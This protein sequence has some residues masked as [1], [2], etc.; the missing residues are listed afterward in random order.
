MGSGTQIIPKDS[1]H[2]EV[3][4]AGFA[5][6]V[7]ATALRQRGWSVTLHERGPE[8]RALGAGI[9]LWKNSLQV[10]K[11][12]GALDD[13]MSQSMTPPF[14]ETRMNNEVVSKEDFGGLPWRTMTRSALHEA[15]VGA[16]MKSGVEIKVNSYV[17][18]A[19][20]EG[21]LTLESGEIRRADLVV[22]ADGV[23]SKVRDSIGFKQD[24][25]ESRDGI[26]RLIVP[27]NREL[28]GPGDWDNVI[29]FWN[30][31]PRVL[32]V[33]YIPCTKDH[34]YLALMSPKDD[35]EGSAVPINFGVWAENFPHLRPVLEPAAK[36]H[37]RY[38]GYITNVLDNWTKG[39]VALIG[40]SAHAMCPALA[41]GAGT[42]MQNAYTLAVAATASTGSMSDSLVAWE[43]SE[44]GIT[45]R[46]QERSAYFAATRSMAN[47]NQFTPT[48]LETAFYDPTEIGEHLV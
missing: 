36:I 6:L 9:L 5:G 18:S 41:Q 35:K 39:S 17:T 40:D 14:Y 12:I 28:L 38:D 45:D 15:L 42:A 10:L 11:A 7:A 37:G 30:L 29:D 47:G 22:G 20:P 13:V 43:S 24:R 1:R 33:L 2:A 8:L 31:E 23:H 16:A 4:G 44:R 46:C 21:S 34:L 26:T 25:T 19:D 3:S 27:R 32:R 48:M